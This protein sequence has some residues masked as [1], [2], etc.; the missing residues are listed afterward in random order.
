MCGLLATQLVCLLALSNLCRSSEGPKDCKSRL[1]LDQRLASTM[2]RPAMSLIGVVKVHSSLL[3]SASASAAL[4]PLAT[5]LHL[6]YRFD[7][8]YGL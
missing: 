3:A 6:I 4:R 8:L 2:E 1:L 7:R 5:D